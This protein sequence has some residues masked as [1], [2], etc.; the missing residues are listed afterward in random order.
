[1][2]CRAGGL[3]PQQPKQQQQRQWRRLW[4]RVSV[5]PSSLAP[6]QVRACFAEQGRERGIALDAVA[7]IFTTYKGSTTDG[8]ASYPPTASLG[9]IPSLFTLLMLAGAGTAER[10]AKSLRAQLDSKYGGSTAFEVLDIEQYDAPSELPKEKLVF[11]LMATYGDGDP[12]D[13]ATD[14]WNWLSE[15]AGSGADDDLLQVGWL[16]A[17]QPDRQAGSVAGR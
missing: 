8:S 11:L 14:F 9:V 3:W 15:A 17:G 13:S 6:R 5:A 1:V 2:D 7:H 10:F 4:T 16:R 12:T